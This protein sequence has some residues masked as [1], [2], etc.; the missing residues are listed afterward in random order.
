MIWTFV[1]F[2]VIFQ[3]CCGWAKLLVWSSH[4]STAAHNNSLLLCCCV[5][6]FTQKNVPPS[7]KYCR[8]NAYIYY[9]NASSLFV[10]LPG[11]LLWTLTHRPMPTADTCSQGCYISDTLLGG[12]KLMVCFLSLHIAT[13]AMLNG[14]LFVSM[15]L[16]AVPDCCYSVIHSESKTTEL[17]TRQGKTWNCVPKKKRRKYTSLTTVRTGW[18]VKSSGPSPLPCSGSGCSSG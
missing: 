1:F 14:V 13:T 10:A 7:Y 15:A 8:R 11:R 6:F 2:K 9:N 5:F 17:P 16:K 3:W 4:L 12:N 18:Q